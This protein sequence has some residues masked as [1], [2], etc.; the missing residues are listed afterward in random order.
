[1]ILAIAEL[2]S[3]VTN[4]GKVNKNVAHCRAETPRFCLLC[5]SSGYWNRV[6]QLSDK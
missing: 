1:M 4:L 5:L 2:L 6:L 3:K